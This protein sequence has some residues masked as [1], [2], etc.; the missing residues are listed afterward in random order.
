V[1]LAST[2]FEALG[3]PVAME[4]GYAVVQP[5]EFAVAAATS[6]CEGGNRR[7]A[8]RPPGRR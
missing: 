4:V 7:K 6:A 1:M 3:S 2:S 8:R 5:A